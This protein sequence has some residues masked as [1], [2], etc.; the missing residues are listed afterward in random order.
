MNVLAVG[1]HP[2]DLEISCYGALAKYRAQGHDVA[3]CHI[4]NGNLGH[5]V[6]M[7]DELRE[8]RFKEAEAAAKVIGATHYSIDVDDLYVTAE[9][10]T[11]IKKLAAVVR[12][13]K[14]DVVITHWEKDYMND[15]MQ[16][17]YAT[18][19]ATFAASCPHY[20]LEATTS[21]VPISPIYHMDTVSGAGF[22]PTEYVDISDVIDLKLEALSCHKSQ[23]QWMLDH[24]GI[25]FLDF[26]RTCSKVRGYQCG[27][28]YAEG[29]RLS[30]NYLRMVPRRLLP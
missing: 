3:V 7:P 16:T 5:A 17:Y 24:D 8:I 2:D 30:Q 26:V 28:K 23:L 21:S 14:P 27:V 1:C 12:E 25:D 20:D 13:V 15:H 29:Y 9:N 6:I 18:F 11:L 4:A 19:R 22:L 10:D